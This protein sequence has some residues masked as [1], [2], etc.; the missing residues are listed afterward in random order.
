M[1]PEIRQNSIEAG[2]YAIRA[3]YTLYGGKRFSPS[4]E[5]EKGDR[6]GSR[7]SFVYQSQTRTNIEALAYILKT[8]RTV[9]LAKTH[10]RIITALQTSAA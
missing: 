10:D 3:S 5:E 1:G 7:L 8:Q 2:R 6:R 4:R 9:Y